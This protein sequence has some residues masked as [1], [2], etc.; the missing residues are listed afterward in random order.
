MHASA[1]PCGMVCTVF[2]VRNTKIWLPQEPKSL[3]RSR[4]NRHMPLFG[5]CLHLYHIWLT[6]RLWCE[7][8]TWWH[9]TVQWLSFRFF[10]RFTCKRGSAKHSVKDDHAFL[11]KHAIFRHLPSRNPLT[12]QDEILHDWLR[13]R[14]YAMCQ[15]SVSWRR[16]HR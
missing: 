11:W 6:S 4:P 5:W 15:K 16:P 14:C 13:R 8:A 3:N 9:L 12:D 2:L 10:L 1:T 7:P